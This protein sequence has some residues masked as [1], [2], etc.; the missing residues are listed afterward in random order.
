MKYLLVG[1]PKH[2]EQVEIPDNRRAIIVPD[3]TPI[4]AR[5]CDPGDQR[6]DDFRI[7]TVDYERT[8]VG[9]DRIVYIARRTNR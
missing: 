5:Y 7:R 4:T 6:V 9:S 1:G 8:D 2:G 3:F